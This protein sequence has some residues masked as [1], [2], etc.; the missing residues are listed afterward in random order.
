MKSCRAYPTSICTLS[1]EG[2][3]AR[4]L[5]SINNLQSYKMNTYLLYIQEQN[6]SG[7]SLYGHFAMLQ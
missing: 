3:Q 2:M 4:S 6:S 5:K 1:K 7:V